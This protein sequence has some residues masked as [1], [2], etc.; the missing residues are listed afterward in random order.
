[1]SRASETV[2][3]GPTVGIISPSAPPRPGWPAKSPPRALSPSP[4]RKMLGCVRASIVR[5]MATSGMLSR[6]MQDGNSCL[7]QSRPR[8]I[9]AVRARM[10]DIPIL[11]HCCPRESKPA[12]ERTARWRGGR[13]MCDR[14][15][16]Q[17]SFDG[18]SKN[19]R[20]TPRLHSRGSA[21]GASRQK[22][23]SWSAWLR[24]RK[25]RQRDG[26]LRGRDSRERTVKGVLAH[27]R[28]AAKVKTLLADHGLPNLRQLG[29]DWFGG[30]AIAS[31]F[32]EHLGQ[33]LRCAGARCRSRLGVISMNRK[34]KG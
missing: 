2:I 29:S 17:L 24:E 9:R 15:G 13:E 23:R 11:L 8:W 30:G 16:A 22:G 14:R 7:Q 32:K 18:L 31:A 20:S 12:Y 25:I 33:G 27:C 19:G 1:M 5:G 26:R 34:P 28:I 21:R 6:M 4:V 10:A 3:R